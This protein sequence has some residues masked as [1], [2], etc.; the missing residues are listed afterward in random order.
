MRP[1]KVCS[2]RSI[3]RR[4]IAFPTFSNMAAAAIMNWNFDILDHPQS[5]LCGSI[6]LS[7]F[8]VDLIF[9][10]EDIVIL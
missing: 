1:P 9:A 10:M 3:G 6:T 2:N 7:K 8:G 4:V 5:E